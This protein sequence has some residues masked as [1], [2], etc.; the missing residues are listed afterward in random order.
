MAAANYS[1]QDVQTLLAMYADMQ[2]DGI[3]AIAEKL[4]KPVRSIRSKLVRLGVYEAPDKVSNKTEGPSKKELLRDLEA[5]GFDTNGF[6][7]AT[8][9]ALHR[10]LGLV[11]N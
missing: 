2:N 8:K 1:E 3:P 4:G 6:E 9:P 7:G 5:V 10:L 11:K